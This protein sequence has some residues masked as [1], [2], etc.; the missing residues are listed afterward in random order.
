MLVAGW[1]LLSMGTAK[2][3]WQHLPCAGTRASAASAQMDVAG[4]AG[5]QSVPGMLE[6]YEIKPLL[7]HYGLRGVY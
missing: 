1:M 3:T 6:T 4:A 5:S 2:G 7:L